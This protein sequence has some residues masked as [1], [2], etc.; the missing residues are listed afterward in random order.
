ML[1]Q[2]LSNLKHNS[3][4]YKTCNGIL[5][6]I[7]NDKDFILRRCLYIIRNYSNNITCTYPTFNE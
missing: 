5:N 2:Y 4:S 7:I 6:V 1:R 3:H